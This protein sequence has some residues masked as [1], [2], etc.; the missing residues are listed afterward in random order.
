[1]ARVSLN[2][3]PDGKILVIDTVSQ[4]RLNTVENPKI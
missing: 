4:I 2:D 3:D 1:M